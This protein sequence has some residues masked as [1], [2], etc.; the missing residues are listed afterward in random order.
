MGTRINKVPAER[1]AEIA[2]A[3]GAGRA[4][5]LPAEKRAD[6]A[7]AGAAATN[8]PLNYAQ[9]IRRAWKGMDRTDRAAVREVLAGCT[10]L[11]PREPKQVGVIKRRPAAPVVDGPSES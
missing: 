9:R 10:G 7:R 2:S 6:I 8:S 1:R 5:A 3:G 11:F 4:A